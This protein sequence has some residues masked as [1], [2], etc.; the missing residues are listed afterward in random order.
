MRIKRDH[1]FLLIYAMFGV[2]FYA[3][4]F[5]PYMRADDLLAPKLLADSILYTRMCPNVVKWDEWLWLRDAGP[6]L[7]LEFTGQSL[8]L[9]TL[10]N[11]SLLLVVTHAVAR[12]YK[13]SK[14][15][16][17]AFVLINPM[18]FLSLL[19]PNKEIFGLASALLLLLFMRERS[20][21]AFAGALIFAFFARVSM[22][23]AVLAFQLLCLT[24]IPRV[25]PAHPGRFL[26]RAAL[27]A[28]VV[29]TLLALVFD[30]DAK[31]PIL[32]DFSNEQDTSQS[33][34]VS[35]SMERLSAQG[36]YV[37]TWAG[38][39]FLNLYGALAN[40]G[41]A[42]IAT[43]GVYY[44]VGITGS[45]ILFLILTAQLLG[46]R[47]RRHF[48]RG[49]PQG[50]QM[51]LFVLIYTMLLCISPVIQ[52]RYFFPLYPLFALALVVAAPRRRRRKKAPL[53][54]PPRP[55]GVEPVAS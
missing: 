7:A 41:S 40:M 20:L 32:G 10:G 18:T 17:L 12:S 52:H 9:V 53:E 24:V 28:L 31:T 39:V 47:N 43:H 29:F 30:S 11:C 38:R 37:L 33:T 26:G 3:A 8:L 54:A 55:E 4:V 49:N 44:A 45:S 19:G 2:I 6:C 13:V 21:A 5:V 1:L 48:L 42:S 15:R 46:R 27:A 34:L 23:V 14:H 22:L 36:L 51:G 35:L 50:L 16:L 25:N